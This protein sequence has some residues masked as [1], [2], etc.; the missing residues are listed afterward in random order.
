MVKARAELLT[1]LNWAISALFELESLVYLLGH[2]EPIKML[3]I[4]K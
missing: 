3:S 4:S 2:S 1:N